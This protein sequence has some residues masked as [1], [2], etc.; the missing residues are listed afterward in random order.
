MGCK[1]LLKYN[2]YHMEHIYLKEYFT[3]KITISP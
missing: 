2:K 1:I 3:P